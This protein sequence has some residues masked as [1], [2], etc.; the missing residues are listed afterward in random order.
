STPDLGRRYAR[1]R[2]RFCE[3]NVEQIHDIAVNEPDVQRARLMID[4][5]KWEASKV[6]QGTYGDRVQVAGDAAQ[7]LVVQVLKLGADNPATK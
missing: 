3:A 7:P 5:I 1:A 2:E 6:L 4:A